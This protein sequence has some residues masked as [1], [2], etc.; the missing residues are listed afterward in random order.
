MRLI[1]Y[2]D[3]L[4]WDADARGNRE[5]WTTHVCKRVFYIL[6]IQILE[7]RRIQNPFD[8]DSSKH[9]LSHGASVQAGEKISMAGLLNEFS[10]MGMIHLV[11]CELG[12]FY[13]FL[14]VYQIIMSN[15][16]K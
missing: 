12:S 2:N 4:D 7:V 10:S 3:A 11:Y 5:W 9:C 6:F 16:S 14:R 13:D 1:R 8:F 15:D